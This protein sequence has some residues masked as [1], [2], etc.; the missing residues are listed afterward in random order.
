MTLNLTVT[1]PRCIY[2]SADFRLRDWTTGDLRDFETQ[3]IVLVTKSRWTATVCFAGVGRTHK[4][5]VGDWLAERI[6][7]IESDDPFER[8][9]D[10]LLTANVWLSGASIPDKRHSFSVGAFVGVEPVF[11]LV[12]NFETLAEP[13]APSARS[14]LTVSQMRPSEPKTFVAGQQQEVSLLQRSQLEKLAAEKPLHLKL[15]MRLWLN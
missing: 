8:L 2:Q 7:A 10:E 12:S 3:K 5:N 11:A 9:L 1:T 6:A 14:Q 13:P 4:V 15:C